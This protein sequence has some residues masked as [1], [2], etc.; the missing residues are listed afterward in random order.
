MKIKK[1]MIKKDSQKDW[2]KKKVEY[3]ERNRE[4]AREIYIFIWTTNQG[5]R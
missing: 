4:I 5:Y 2:I 1:N 3:N